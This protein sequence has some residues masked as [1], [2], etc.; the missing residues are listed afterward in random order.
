MISTIFNIDH[1]TKNG[2]IKKQQ[3]KRESEVKFFNLKKLRYHCDN[4]TVNGTVSTSNEL[5]DLLICNHST[6]HD[7]DQLKF[8][9]ISLHPDQLN[10]LHQTTQLQTLILTV[11]D[12]RYHPPPLNLCENVHKSSAPSQSI[13]MIRI[14]SNDYNREDR[15]KDADDKNAS[16]H[17]FEKLRLPIFNNLKTLKVY[18][19]PKFDYSKFFSLLMNLS[20]LE[21]LSLSYSCPVHL[22][23]KDYA[24]IPDNCPNLRKLKLNLSLSRRS[25]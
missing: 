3:A 10:Y 19:I 14:D 7:C 15:D 20:N 9:K 16:V 21:N 6:N 18:E 22:Q 1:F 25:Y 5:L 11:L 12:E 24:L 23:S 2:K 4:R 17:I 8:L 13:T